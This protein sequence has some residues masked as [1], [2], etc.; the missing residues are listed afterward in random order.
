MILQT[1]KIW[2]PSLVIV[3]NWQFF[4][5]Y[6][7]YGKKHMPRSN[8]RNDEIIHIFFML[9]RPRTCFISWDQKYRHQ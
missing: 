7:S 8:I 1:I 3:R 9:K 5:L 6:L 4:K 2:V